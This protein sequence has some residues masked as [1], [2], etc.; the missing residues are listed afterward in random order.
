MTDNVFFPISEVGTR[1][2]TLRV[3]FSHFIPMVSKSKTKTRIK[4]LK[5]NPITL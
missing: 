4:T 1:A 3:I 2:V 5:K